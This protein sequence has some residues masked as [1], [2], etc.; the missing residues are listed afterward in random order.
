MTSVSLIN[1][2]WIPLP[3]VPPRPG[4]MEFMFHAAHAPMKLVYSRSA[5]PSR[6]LALAGLLFSQRVVA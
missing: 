2:L 1:E 6:G 5:Y 3:E 4:D